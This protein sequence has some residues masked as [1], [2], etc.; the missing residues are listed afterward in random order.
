ME[1]LADGLDDD[2]LFEAEALLLSR[3][4]ADAL[5]PSRVVAEFL[6]D[7]MVDADF[8][9]PLFIF[10]LLLLFNFFRWKSPPAGHPNKFQGNQT[11]YGVF[12]WLDAGFA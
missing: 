7:S 5:W 12:D 10:V 2:D 6:P 8:L 1:L 3:V 9:L 4:E 11:G